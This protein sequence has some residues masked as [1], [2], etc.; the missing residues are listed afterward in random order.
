MV[1][2]LSEFLTYI[3]LI[4]FYLTLVLPAFG[5]T[6]VIG[7]TSLQYNAPPCP[8]GTFT[9]FSNDGVAIDVAIKHKNFVAAGI[10]RDGQECNSIGIH[11]DEQEYWYYFDE[12]DAKW[13]GSE[14]KCVYCSAANVK[15]VIYGDTDSLRCDN[16]ICNGIDGDTQCESACGASAACD[17]VV[18]GTAGACPGDPDG[19]KCLNDCVCGCESNADCAGLTCGSLGYP[20]RKRYCDIGTKSCVCDPCS[21]N[22]DCETGYCCD[23]KD[24]PG[25]GKIAG[26]CRSAST[27]V[28]LKWLCASG[29]PEEWYECNKNNEG[30]KKET[31][32]NNYICSYSEGSYKWV[33]SSSVLP[34]ES[35]LVLFFV[36]IFEALKSIFNS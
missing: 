20:N 7:P 2:F 9:K 23:R 21:D 29:S 35:P 8:V 1:S 32:E 24:D 31:S 11:S 6:G 19:T 34:E 17:E 10:S 13:D 18:L 28:D 36:R 14:D 25:P 22:P 30:L 27:I 33:T 3:R 4:I 16:D 15:L 12:L 26:Q 5:D